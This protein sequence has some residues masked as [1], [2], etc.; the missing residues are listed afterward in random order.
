MS[1]RVDWSAPALK[2]MTTTP[3]IRHCQRMMRT[4][5][6]VAERE[7]YRAELRRLHG[8][9]EAQP[10]AMT[11]PPEMVDAVREGAYLALDTAIQILARAKFPPGHKPDPERYEQL[12]TTQALLDLTGRYATIPPASIKV[13]LDEHRLTL[14]DA[15]H[16]KLK[17]DTQLGEAASA[18]RNRDEPAATTAT[19]SPDELAEFI[20]TVE[21][22][23]GARE[24][25]C[26]L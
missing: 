4:A 25:A 21:A 3:R 11:V 24:P 18:A 10:C 15:L 17:A 5:T 19:A 9:N 7:G 22:Q 23:G 6:S 8:E 2:H 14:L 12:E 13:D 26:A 20:A 1:P 16:R